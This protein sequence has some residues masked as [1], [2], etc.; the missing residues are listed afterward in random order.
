MEELELGYSSED[1]F[2]LKPPYLVLIDAD[3]LKRMKNPWRIDLQ[4]LLPDFFEKMMKTEVGSRYF[5][6]MG[7]ALETAAKIYK[8]K[9]WYLFESER[10]EAERRELEKKKRESKDLPSLRVPVRHVSESMSKGE[11]MDQ[12]IE[13]LMAEK[14][15]TE[16]RMKQQKKTKEQKIRKA[17][18]QRRVPLAEVMTKEDFA[19][20]VD[21]DRMNVQERNKQVYDATKALLNA[22]PADKREI[23][24]EDII[25]AM[26][27]FIKD[28]RIMVARVLL[29]ILFLITDGLLYAEQEVES[30]RIWVLYP[31]K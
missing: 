25:K 17:Q 28:P 22:A 26:S 14:K 21:T 30:K 18:R 20:E 13:V 8:A 2:Y 16:R 4:T 23:R 15:R 29:A 5:R 7:K 12:L 3:L 6:I 1:K 31:P 27:K 11:L 9:V 24:F 19:Y 10:K